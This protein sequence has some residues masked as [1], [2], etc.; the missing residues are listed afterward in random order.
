M[1]KNNLSQMIFTDKEI[2][3]FKITELV[4]LGEEVFI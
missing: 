1:Q 2:G 4:R 3:R